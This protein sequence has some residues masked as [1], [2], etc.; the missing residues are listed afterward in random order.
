MKQQINNTLLYTN[1]DESLYEM[2]EPEEKDKIDK[3]LDSTDNLA[4]ATSIISTYF[5]ETKAVNHSVENGKLVQTPNLLSGFSIRFTG[6][7]RSC[8]SEFIARII[9]YCTC[10]RATI[11]DR[12]DMI[13]VEFELNHQQ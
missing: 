13:E 3:L 1:G 2:L 4:L 9:P 10:L 7:Y 12:G 5:T 6:D 8:H 11:K